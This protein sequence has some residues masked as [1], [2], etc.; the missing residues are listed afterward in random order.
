MMHSVTDLG[1]LTIASGQTASPSMDFRGWRRSASGISIRGPG[2]LTGTVKVQTSRD[3]TNWSD[4]ESAGADITVPADGQIV[5]KAVI[6]KYLRLLSGS[7]E[8]SD[9]IFYLTGESGE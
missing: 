8:G 3:D 9:R 7:A 5:I 6:W 2:T 4:L 1:S